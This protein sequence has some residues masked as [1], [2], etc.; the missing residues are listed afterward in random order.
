[1][2]DTDY[3]FTVRPLSEDEGGGYLVESPICP[4][5]CRMARR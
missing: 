5:A 4:A 1:M 2:S 3:R